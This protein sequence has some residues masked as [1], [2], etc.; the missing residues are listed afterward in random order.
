MLTRHLIGPAVVAV[1]L[2]AGAAQAQTA[3]KPALALKPFSVTA[4]RQTPIASTPRAAVFAQS[5]ALRAAGIARTSV[6][7]R[8]EDDGTVGSVGF[9]CGLQPSHD[10][11]GVSSAYGSDPNG[12]FLGAK[13]SRAF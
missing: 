2:V 8:F 3:P 12:R 4:E 5:N 1:A 7:R 10:Y 11:S 6:D 9:L 13:F